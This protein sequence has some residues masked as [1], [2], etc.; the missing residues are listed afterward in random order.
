MFHFHHFTEN[1]FEKKTTYNFMLEL[2]KMFTY[3]R[4]MYV[5][6]HLVQFNRLHHRIVNKILLM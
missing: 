5:A 6:V 4:V 1:C 2:V 3:I